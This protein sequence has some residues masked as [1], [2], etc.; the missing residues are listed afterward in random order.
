MSS[1]TATA[2][3]LAARRLRAGAR[4]RGQR[5]AVLFLALIVLVVMLLVGVSMIRKAGTGGSISGNLAF[6]QNATSVA[7]LGVE[8]ARAWISANPTL[9]NSDSTANGYFSSW[10]ANVTPDTF[11]AGSAP[12]VVN[13]T[14][15]DGTGNAVSY[16]IHRLCQLPNVSPDDATQH[17]VAEPDAGAG[18]TKGG[19]DYG[20]AP[21]STPTGLPYYRITTRVVGPRNTLSYVQ[22]VMY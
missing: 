19:I 22:V 5:G 20:S 12:S 17:C 15:D 11:W 9:L 4:H 7:D 10:S 21:S 16:V 2:S 18:A 3:F 14:S 6:K 13:V 8:A 1:R